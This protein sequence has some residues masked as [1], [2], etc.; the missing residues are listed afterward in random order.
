MGFDADFFRDEIRN[1]FYIPT[2]I[3][4]AWA[5]ELTVLKEIDRICR[6]YG[7]GYFAEYGTLLGAVRHGGFIPWDDDLDICMKREDYNRFR[8]VA[9]SELPKDYVFHDYKTRD[10]HWM[11]LA[12]VVNNSHSCFEED[13]LNSF[14]NFPWLAGVDIFQLDYLY[15]DRKREEKRDK[16]ILKL[17]AIAEGITENS[18]N[19]IS[20]GREL[21]LIEQKYHVSILT[22]QDK[23]KV[24]E[25]LFELAEGLMQKVKEE[26]AERIGQIFPWVLKGGEGYPKDFFDKI[27]RLPFENTDIPVPVGYFDL[28][29]VH[30]GN[31]FEVRKTW[32]GHDYPFFEGQKREFVRSANVMLPEFCF[33]EDML[34]RKT[35]QKDDS[36]KTI[37]VECIREFKACLIELEECNIADEKEELVSILEFC[38][39]TAIDLGTLIEHVKGEES[40]TTKAIVKALEDYCEVLYFYSQCEDKAKAS[41]ILLKL[42]DAVDLIESET[43]QKL[44]S[45]K[46]V[47][48]LPVGPAEWRAFGDIYDNYIRDNE[49][50]VFVVPLPLFI[51]DIYGRVRMSEKEIEAAVHKNG[52]PE[53]IELSDWRIFDLSLHCPEVVYIQNPYDVVNPCLSVPP[54]FYAGN[55]VKF[56]EELVYVPI[57]RTSE[58]SQEDEPEQ[59]NLK[60]Y[61]TVPGVIFSDIVYVQSENIREQYINKLTAF[62]GEG[63]EKAWQDKIRVIEKEKAGAVP[64]KHSKKTILYCIGMNELREHKDVLTEAVGKRLKA[65]EHN[66]NKLEPV[67]YLFPQDREEWK[68]VDEKLS[69]ELFSLIDKEAGQYL[70]TS[71]D[72]LVSETEKLADSYS[73]YYGSPSPFVMAFVDRKKPVMISD[74]GV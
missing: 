68:K 42:S 41:D 49:F 60:H 26:D 1:G 30:Y 32:T 19:P 22:L 71:E 43:E 74:Y 48:F 35:V 46:E 67:V 10:D 65:L 62:A 14:Y 21:N 69:E 16:E 52:Y 39:R 58:F 56:T 11:F 44:L 33:D 47:L 38:Q 45:R 37:A 34:K 54:T 18:I 9:P 72:S 27:V 2:A 12:R 53:N 23:K 15:K 4:Q 20:L 28:L 50:D 17:V 25:K 55:L 3:K 73:A 31:I 61:V 40:K 7:I 13:H 64:E 5:A 36:L 63:T 57:G 6:K 66:K 29:T 24:A 59:Y 51:K 70:I 8:E